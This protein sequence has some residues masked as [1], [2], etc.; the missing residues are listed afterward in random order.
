MQNRIELVFG[1]VGPVGSLTHEAGENLTSAIKKMDYKPTTI[2]LSKEMDRLLAAKDATFE[3]EL[4]S[5]LHNK[6]RKGNAVRKKFGNNAV[7]ASEAIRLIIDFRRECAVEAGEQDPVTIDDKSVVPLDGHAFIVDQLK[8]PE[9][10]DLLIKTF[11]KRFIQVSVVTPLEE[12]R[13]SLNARIRR[14]RFG[15]EKEFYAQHVGQ[16]IT[17]DQNKNPTI[18]ANGS[19]RFFTWEMFF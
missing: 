2:S 17:I 8:L 12:R 19:R 11:G 1:L 4:T 18:E 13:R 7:L 10:V 16:L 5:V 3:D 6:I 15:W 9:E 14:E